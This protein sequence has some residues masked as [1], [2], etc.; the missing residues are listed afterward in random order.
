MH[1]PNRLFRS[2]YKVVATASPK[3]FDILYERGADVVLDYRSADVGA[4]INQRTNNR[5]RHVLD[6]VAIPSTA[7]ICAAAFGP[8]GGVYCSLLP[9]QCPREKVTSC[10]FL[11][12]G[13]T[14]EDYIFESEFYTAV[15]DMYD[16][17]KE[18][19]C[20]IE[21]LW[22]Q[23]RLIAHPQRVGGGGL[24]GA[25]EGMR[26]MKD[27]KVSGFKLVYRVDDTPWP[28]AITK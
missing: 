5:L 15:P 25:L 1:A 18:A 9:E 6:C 19:I 16:F 22:T 2:G 10:F 7:Q 3:H 12:Y 17:G 20:V 13:L 11:G 26:E 21:V 14:G 4:Q 23:D 28:D 8:D 27:G 24:Q